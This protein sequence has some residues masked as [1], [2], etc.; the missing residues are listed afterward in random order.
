MFK[1]MMVCNQGTAVAEDVN[2]HVRL[3]IKLA[4]LEKRGGAMGEIKNCKPE[5][6]TVRWFTCLRMAMRKSGVSPKQQQL[7]TWESC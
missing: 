5:E 1:V 4:V 2:K 3:E 6:C 7:S